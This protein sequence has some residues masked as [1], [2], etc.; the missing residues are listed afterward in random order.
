MMDFLLAPLVYPFMVRALIASIIVGIVC[1]VVG[2]YVVLRGMAFLGDALAHSILP[3]VAIGYLLGKGAKGPIFWGAIVAAILASLGIGALSKQTKLREDASIGIIF[4][5]MLA[6][7]I[8]IISS[9]RNYAVDLAHFLFGNVLAV[10]WGDLALIA[11]LGAAVIITVMAFYKEFMVMAFDPILASTLRIK[12]DL[13]NYIF[14]AMI[15]VTVVVSLQ[16]VGVAL[17]VA[18]L[19]TPAATAYLLANRLPA[20]MALSAAI[21]VV[22]GI[23]GLYLSYYLGVASGAS[24]VL[25]A[26]VFFLL[27]FVFS[28]KRRP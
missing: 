27:A 12:A 13:L 7:G 3:G 14:L 8:A 20:M 24:I 21:G 10:S 2:S 4:A 26:T 1:G 15:S 6:L 18:L 11:G 22:S 17:A 5:G 19:I 16:T 28:R 25:V 23:I 9:V